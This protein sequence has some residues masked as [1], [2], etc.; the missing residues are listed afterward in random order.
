MEVG[1]PKN[2]AVRFELSKARGQFQQLFSTFW[3]KERGS[4]RG[5]EEPL[6]L[7]A[8]HLTPGP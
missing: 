8:L 4:R 1:L 3:L 2:G 6:D 7:G 5:A